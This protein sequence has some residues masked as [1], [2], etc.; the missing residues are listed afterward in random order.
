M[1]VTGAMSVA[2]QE[3]ATNKA[4]AGFDVLTKTLQKAG[5]NEMN[6]QHRLSIAEHT[7]KGLNINIT[8]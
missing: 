2:A 6:D 1:E 4:Q 8:A 5:Q 7:G 3:M